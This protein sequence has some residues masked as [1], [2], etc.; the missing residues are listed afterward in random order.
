MKL[1]LYLD[2]SVFSAYYDEGV[3]D[4]KSQTEQFWARRAE[5]ELSTSALAVQEL[6]QTSER[7]RRAELMALVEGLTIHAIT[8]EMKALASRYVRAEVFTP[9]MYNDALHVAAAVLTRQDVLLS[10]NFKHLVNRRRRARI[11]EYN[12]SV[13]LPAVEIVA[14]PEV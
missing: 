6:E 11:N 12:I 7:E 14:P 4:R 1:R 2:T 3:T 8:P 10:W 5:F 9:V 13:G